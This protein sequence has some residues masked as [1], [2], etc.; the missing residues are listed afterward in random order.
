MVYDRTFVYEFISLAKPD[1][2][3]LIF[4]LMAVAK[5]IEGS[6]YLAKLS[7]FFVSFF[8]SSSVTLVITSLLSG[9]F[10]SVIMNDAA[11][12]FAVPLAVAIATRT[13]IS[14]FKAA[15]V[16][17]AGVNVG[18]ALTP[19]GNPQNILIWKH[20]G[21]GFL[22]FIVRMFPY[23][24]A[25]M[26]IIVTYS[27]LLVRRHS[28]S[29]SVPPPVVTRKDMLAAGVALLLLNVVMANYGLVFYALA[30]TLVVTTAV[31][32]ELVLNLDLPLLLSFMLMFASLGKIS[33]LIPTD[34]ISSWV[35]SP[36]ATYFLTAGL[37]QVISNVPATIV[38]ENHVRDWLPLTIGANIGGCGVIIGSLANVITLRLVGGG[39]RDLHKYMLPLFAVLLLLN[40]ALIILLT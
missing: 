4:S 18:S 40:A 8:R 26:A 34:P 15:A 9:L 12:F 6:G 28:K 36:L 17:T 22:D 20:F 7:K 27:L 1:T 25:S 35:S 29:P 19:I 16:V 14:K 32:Y 2:L 21:I 33:R 13:G 30:I 31:Q 11:L 38:L 39:L 5:L 23:V 24:A 3:A 37:S 10:A